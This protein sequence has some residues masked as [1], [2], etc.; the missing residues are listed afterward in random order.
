MKILNVMVLFNFFI[1]T[2]CVTMHTPQSR[3]EY[4]SA[5]SKGE[6]FSEIHNYMVNRS[7]KSVVNSLHR[8]GNECLAKKVTRSFSG[9]YAHVSSSTY[10]PSMRYT[11]KSNAE[12]TLQVEITPNNTSKPPKGGMY[13]L[14]A[15]LIEVSQNKTKIIMYAPSINAKDIVN[16]IKDWTKGENTGCPDLP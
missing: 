6:G 13:F 2:S 8:K 15:D 10:L 14:A 11:S 7:L 9:S 5:V 1:L 3:N 16:S 4:V 12:F